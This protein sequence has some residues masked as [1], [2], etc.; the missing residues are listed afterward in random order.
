MIK[1]ATAIVVLVV[2]I[3]IAANYKVIA[4]R[5]YPL[6]Y[7]IYVEKYSKAYNLDKYMVYSII[8]VESNFNTN[9]KSSKKAIGLM[10]I[11]PKT[12][13]YIADLLKDNN[14]EDTHL[15]DA[16]LNIKYGCF[17]L[18]K[19]IND[20]G[21]DMD[22]ALAAY[23]GGEGNV[24]KWLAENE[25]GRKTLDIE[26]VPYTETKAYVKRVKLIINIYKYLYD[27]QAKNS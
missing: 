23:N 25:K 17:Y 14:Y 13:K 15:F 11:T 6:D 24:R 5:V 4:K 12:G 9:A 10:Q 26:N 27:T 16:D 18:S 21:G 20:F 1:K 3:L 8:K 7:K 22:C 19:L 2:L